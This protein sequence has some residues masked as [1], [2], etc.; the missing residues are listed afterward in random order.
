[1]FMSEKLPSVQ[2][3]HLVDRIADESVWFGSP[4]LADVLVGR[5]AVQRPEPAREIVGGLNGAESLGTK[6]NGR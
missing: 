2:S 1:M 3:R 4:D 5:K 6:A